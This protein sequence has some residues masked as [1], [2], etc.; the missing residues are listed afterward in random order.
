MSET[1]ISKQIY[2]AIKKTFPNIQIVRHHCGL[3]KGWNGGVMQLGE[4]GWP[5]YIGY[6][7]NGRFLGV[8]VK[9]ANGKTSK[10]RLEKQLAR[11][12]DIRQKGGIYLS[13]SNVEEC[14]NKLKDIVEAI[15][16]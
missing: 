7:P 9:D 5:D 14:L 12:F 3:A 4:E 8:E 6:L 2:K 11:G 16:G 10:D 15:N 13:V 1:V